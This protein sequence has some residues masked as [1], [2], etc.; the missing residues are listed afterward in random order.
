MATA[1]QTAADRFRICRQRQPLAP[2]RT[3]RA[4]PLPLTVAPSII[5]RSISRSRGRGAHGVR[6]RAMTA[7]RGRR[8]AAA[9]GTGAAT[10]T[11]GRSSI[12]GQPPAPP[13]RAA[14]GRGGWVV[15]RRGDRRRDGGA[16][17][18]LVAEG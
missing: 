13:L 4:L 17:A 8:R 16:R 3:H 6:G 1:P 14:E 10:P 5:H 18:W 12:R 7:R 15:A 11:R 2:Y 9:S